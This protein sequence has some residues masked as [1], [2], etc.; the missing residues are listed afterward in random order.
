MW[1][2]QH[3]MGLIIQDITQI[4]DDKEKTRAIFEMLNQIKDELSGFDKNKAVGGNEIKLWAVKD[5][6]TLPKGYKEAN[7]LDGTFKI[8]NENSSYIFIQKVK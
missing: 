6:P 7:G 4:I 2:T 8:S 3:N 1:H 5:N